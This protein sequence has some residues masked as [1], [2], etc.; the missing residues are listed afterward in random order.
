MMG[1]IWARKSSPCLMA[2]P[3]LDGSRVALEGGVVHRREDAVDGGLELVG[4]G[5]RPGIL[6]GAQE[7]QGSERQRQ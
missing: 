7:V 2:G 5:G 1:T 6:G 3:T 4:G